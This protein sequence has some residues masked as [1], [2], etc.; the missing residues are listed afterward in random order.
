MGKMRS[1]RSPEKSTVIEHPKQLFYGRRKARPLRAARQ[2]AY[3]T[4]LPQIQI[5][6]VPRALEFAGGTPKALWVEVGF[7][8]G[9]SLA[10]WH[11][12]H[13][14]V[15]FIGC[16][17]FI[18]GVSNFCKLVVNDD[19]SNIK[20]WTDMAQ[21]LLE[22]LPDASTERL[23]L[24]NSDPWPKKRHHRR[25]FIQQESLTNIA[26]ILKPGG[27]LVMTTDHASL[28]DWML[29]QTLRHPAFTWTAQT[30]ADW[31]TPPEGWLTTRYEGKG[32]VAGRRQVY[33]VFRKTA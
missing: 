13:P 23:Y 6:D 2:D 19:L 17:P 16:E 33:L 12:E 10:A 1:G 15:C 14:D 27:L 9:D 22:A 32:A 31:E 29:E 8:N 25:R 26:R 21:P 11:R 28:A 3:D 18:N 24:L 30:Q 7:G 20:I 5:T 4:V